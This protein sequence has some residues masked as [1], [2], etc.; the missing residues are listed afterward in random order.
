M[1][2]I[3]AVMVI[4]CVSMSALTLYFGKNMINIDNIH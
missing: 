4:I 2:P 1:Q 3:I